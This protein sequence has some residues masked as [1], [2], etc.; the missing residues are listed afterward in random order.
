MPINGVTIKEGAS[1]TPVGGTDITFDDT[2]EEIA[3]GIVCVNQAETDFFAREKLVC[4]S[5][6]P[7]QDAKSGVFSKQKISVRIIDPKKLADGSI[8]YGVGRF[9]VEAHPE[10]GVTQI[11]KIRKLLL[12][13]ANSSSLDALFS[14]G[15]IK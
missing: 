14:V 11:T 10:G 12:A 4:V 1:F 5:R 6:L 8:S 7:V 2:G 9:E 15:S 13:A 3:N